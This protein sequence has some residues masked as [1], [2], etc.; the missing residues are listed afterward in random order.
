[1]K[2]FFKKIEILSH[3]IRNSGVEKYFKENPNHTEIEYPQLLKYSNSAFK[4]AQEM[5]LKLL[6]QELNSRLKLKEES[7]KARQKKDGDQ[8]EIGAIKFKIGLSEFKERILRHV[9]DSIVWQILGGKREII[10]RFYLEE[11]GSTS[12]NDVGFQ[13]TEDFVNEQNKDPDKFALITD[14]TEN[15]QAGDVLM[16]SS[17][18]IEIIEVKTGTKN[19]IAI[20]LFKFYE[21]NKIIENEGIERI[22]DEK[23]KKQMQR[24]QRQKKKIKETKEIIKNEKGKYQKD[25]KISVNFITPTYIQETYREKLLDLIEKSKEKNRAYD[26]IG[27]NPGV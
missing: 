12:L 22:K 6:R 2:E 8:Q 7:K 23:F 20:D 10:A 3:L 14:L 25:E 24:M 4:E 1:M 19:K 18:G 13:A 11:E 15:I 27:N 9:M 21:V 5:V 16:I 26:V 17:R